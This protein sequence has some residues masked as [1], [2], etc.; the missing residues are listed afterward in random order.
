MFRRMAGR[1][2]RRR[3]R[4]PAKKHTELLNRARPH[5]DRLLAEQ[6]GVCAICERLPN[7]KRRFDIDHDHTEMYVRGLLDP[8]CNRALPGWVTPEWLR[9]AADY[10]E[11]GPIPWLEDLM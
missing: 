8:R 2:A 11:R 10:L 9:A 5:Y 6:G 7:P 1:V 3:R 4:R